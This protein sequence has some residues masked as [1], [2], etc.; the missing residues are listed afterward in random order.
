MD[1]TNAY[2]LMDEYDPS[3]WEVNPDEDVINGGQVRYRITDLEG[4]S[5]LT[6]NEHAELEELRSLLSQ[7]GHKDFTA[8]RKDYW[9]DY[10]RE[11]AEDIHGDMEGWPFNRIDWEDAADDLRVD[12]ASTDFAGTTFYVR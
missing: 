7:A 8:V 11:Y 1:T 4:K 6:V 10:V 3:A 5:D 12:Y 9:A 2:R